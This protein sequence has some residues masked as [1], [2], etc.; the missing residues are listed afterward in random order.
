LLLIGWASFRQG[1]CGG[2]IVAAAG[3]IVSCSL[4]SLLGWSTID[5]TM[6]QANLL[7][8][9]SMA[10]LMGVSSSW[11]AASEAR[12]RQVVSHIPVVLYSARVRPPS[13][14][15]A[16]SPRVIIS[17]VSP[18]SKQLLHCDPEELLGDYEH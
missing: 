16:P 4:A 18:A 8:H 13:N 7:A 1:V 17:F 6:V 14:A 2:T 12:Y 15:R 10:L 3:A 9:C 5:Y 11:I